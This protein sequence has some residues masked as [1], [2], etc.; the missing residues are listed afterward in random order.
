MTRR[1]GGS[2]IL[3]ALL[4]ASGY[5]TGRAADEPAAEP[6]PKNGPAIGASGIVVTPE[7]EPIA[8]A[9]VFL[10]AKIGGLQ[11]TFGLRHNRDLLARTTTDKDGQFAFKDVG[12]PP[13]LEDQIEA[14]LRGDAAAELIAWADGRGLAWTDVRQLRTEQPVR[15]VLSP[16]APMTGVVQDAAGKPVA[17]AR[18]TVWGF[19]RAT[20]NLD[21]LFHGPGDLGLSLSQLPLET[22]S[23]PDGR[24]TLAHLPPGCRVSA[25]CESRGHRRQ[26]LILE[27]GDD[28]GLTEIRYGEYDKT[29]HK[30]L[31][32]PVKLVL[33]PERHVLVRVVDH[34]GQS[35]A[36]GAVQAIS[37]GGQFGGWQ[38]VD[39]RGEASFGF[40]GTESVT[41]QYGS[42][43]LVPRLHAA[44]T[45]DIRADDANPQVEIRLP[46]PR[47][48]AGRVVD[49]DTG[50]PVVGAY[51]RYA[52]A[53]AAA[54]DLRQGAFSVAVSG[55]RGEFRLPVVPGKGQI[56]F[57]HLPVHGYL[58]PDLRRPE[59]MPRTEIDV[60]AEGE[61]PLATLKLARG[62]SVRGL[63]RDAAGR[64]LV[65]AIVRGLNMDAP[66]RRA[67]AVTDAEGRF[68]LGGFSPRVALM[69]IVA[70]EAGAAQQTIPVD[71]E[72]P[73]DKTRWIDTELT[74]APGVVL[75][76]RVLKGG[77]P[78]AG[79]R[80]KLSRSLGEEKNRNYEW[81]EVLT[82]A[83]GKY[84]VAGLVAGDRY[85][86]AIHDPDGLMVLDWHHQSPYVQYV[87]EDQ[88]VVELPDVV[89]VS[90]GQRL[91]GVVVDPAG[92]PVAGVTVG[93]SLASGGMLSRRESGPPPWTDTDA[94]GRFELSQL[95]D[96]PIELMAYRRNDQTRFIRFPAKVRPK[97]GQQDIRILLDPTL[98]EP[99][100]D[101]DAPK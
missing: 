99:I 86:F 43:P 68:T 76:G 94:R 82:D 97:L 4:V 17:G 52:Q 6:V 77:R 24:F 83:E 44:M 41:F 71:A 61:A 90:R 32:S 45:A 54:D 14:L 42:D 5:R 62:L 81:T 46:E 56:G 39:A 84:R 80:M 101:L 10:R 85:S 29:V 22:T 53:S 57:W 98:T 37:K 26:P 75:A 95:P 35:V 19:S 1:V 89:L 11:Y 64:P 69:L 15:L 2:L 67:S 40:A 78:R 93:A 20:S 38:A 21:R 73:W 16:E 79:V 33:E 87:P 13:R 7:G 31:R 30:V 92:K 65:K 34:A 63:V 47:W 55:A 58:S 18:L 12:I 36:E 74:L 88:A 3:C 66:Y 27:T 91:R 48:Q 23:G 96:E 8:Q 49:A 70:N 9:S 51:V 28:P 25:L 50:Q 72:H 100:E 60:P 59:A